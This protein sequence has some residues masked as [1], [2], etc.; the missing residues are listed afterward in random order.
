MY[1]VDD[2]N[3]RTKSV[4]K[5]GVTKDLK[6]ITGENGYIV[7]ITTSSMEGEEYKVDKKYWISKKDPLEEKEEKEVKEPATVAQAIKAINF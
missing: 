6:V 1:G 5:D 7:C 4:T 2:E 3:I